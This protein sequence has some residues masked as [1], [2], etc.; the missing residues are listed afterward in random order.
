M[1]NKL[2]KLRA[3]SYAAAIAFH[4][5]ASEYFTVLRDRKTADA[6]V[7]VVVAVEEAAAVYANTLDDLLAHLRPLERTPAIQ[8]ELQR[9]LRIRDLLQHESQL[10]S[11]VKPD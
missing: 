10:M 9:T 2:L 4:R 5:A 1:D 7:P 6:S 11:Q 3:D 8:E